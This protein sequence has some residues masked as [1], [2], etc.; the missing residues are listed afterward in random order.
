MYL[1][2]ASCVAGSHAVILAL[3]ISHSRTISKYYLAA[4]NVPTVRRSR[5]H[6][7][8]GAIDVGDDADARNLGKVDAH[9]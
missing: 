2:C 1:A 5:P 4:T 7:L 8:H 3:Q 6:L 9:D